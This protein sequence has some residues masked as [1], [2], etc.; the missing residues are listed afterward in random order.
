MT[1]LS[2]PHYYSRVSH[3]GK[4]TETFA[5]APPA[6]GA[7]GSYEYW[8]R[9]LGEKP[10]KQSV[11]SLH[12]AADYDRELANLRLLGFR[13]VDEMIVRER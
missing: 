11:T 2:A 3:D 10:V 8:T 1:T 12:T 4:L 9:R 13:A 7:H 6:D 5:V